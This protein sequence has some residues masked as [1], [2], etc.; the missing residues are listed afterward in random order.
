MR[1]GMT[2]SEDLIYAIALLL[3][4]GIRAAG[5]PREEQSGHPRGAVAT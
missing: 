4:W 3:S 1:E 2:S 5:S